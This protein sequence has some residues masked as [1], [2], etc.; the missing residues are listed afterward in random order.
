MTMITNDMLAAALADIVNSVCSILAV[1]KTTVL[2]F[3]VRI[4]VIR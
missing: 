4:F 3:Y 2:L 1:A